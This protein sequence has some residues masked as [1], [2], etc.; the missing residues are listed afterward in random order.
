LDSA[1]RH[2]PRRRVVIREG[3][4]GEAGGLRRGQPG[5]GVVE[6]TI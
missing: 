1:G 4:A 5:V 3:T 2:G 6:S